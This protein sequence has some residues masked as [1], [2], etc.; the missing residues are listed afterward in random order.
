MGGSLGIEGFIKPFV[1]KITGGRV[2]GE[3]QEA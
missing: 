3:C 2:D 1:T